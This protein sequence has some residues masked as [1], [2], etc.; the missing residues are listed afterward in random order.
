MTIQNETTN[1]TDANANGEMAAVYYIT[2]VIDAAA[3][4]GE[5]PSAVNAI[6]ER[7]GIEPGETLFRE[8]FSDFWKSI[9]GEDLF[10]FITDED[11]TGADGEIEQFAVE[12]IGPAF[13]SFW[14]GNIAEG[15]D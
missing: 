13:Q 9:M 11:F 4:T 5:W 1:T 14:L 8:M 2:S 7:H 10:P 12:R 15:I 6:A 3:K